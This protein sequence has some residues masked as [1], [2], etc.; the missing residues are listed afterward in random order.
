[1][2]DKARRVVDAR[3]H[4]IDETTNRIKIIIECVNNHVEVRHLRLQILD[5]LGPPLQLETRRW[6][7]NHQ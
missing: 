3:L 6:V 2:R 5:L 7:F 1:M 4:V